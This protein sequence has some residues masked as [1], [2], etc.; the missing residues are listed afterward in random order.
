MA[1]KRTTDELP[2]RRYGPRAETPITFERGERE[3]DAYDDETEAWAV[4]TF[5]DLEYVDT[6]SE[7]AAVVADVEPDE[8]DGG[9]TDDTADDTEVAREPGDELAGDRR[10]E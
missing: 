9:D 7:A 4:E 5:A 10:D 6:E 3:T 1:I 2:N 8:V